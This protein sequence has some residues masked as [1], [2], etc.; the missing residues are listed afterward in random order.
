MRDTNTRSSSYMEKKNEE[1][2]SQAANKMNASNVEISSDHVIRIGSTSPSTN[3][4]SSSKGSNTISL[5]LGEQQQEQE[6]EEQQ[7]QQQPIHPNGFNFNYKH[8]LL[9][10]AFKPEDEIFETEEEKAESDYYKYQ[11]FEDENARILYIDYPSIPDPRPTKYNSVYYHKLDIEKEFQKRQSAHYR[12]SLHIACLG[13][14]KCGKSTLLGRIYEEFILKPANA[15]RE[16]K[17]IEKEL[18]RRNL[19]LEKKYAWLMDETKIERERNTT[20]GITTDFSVNYKN[21]ELVLYD[22]PGHTDYLS[23]TISE[24]YQTDIILLI[25]DASS[26]NINNECDIAIIKD[27]LFLCKCIGIKDIIIVVNKME[28]VIKN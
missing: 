11:K 4:N 3:K 18:Q 13:P 15:L 19:S 17:K 20:L 1:E 16:I 2:N 5:S 6:E 27:Y 23:T 22:T 25:M 14:I 28:K 7:Q 8:S 26:E 10:N 21:R 12:K 9:E 24:L